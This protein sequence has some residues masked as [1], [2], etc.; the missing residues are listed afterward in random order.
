MPI[1]FHCEACKKKIK[2]PDEAGGKWGACPYCKHRCYIPMPKSDDEPELK[3]A[4][5]D[6][7]EEQ[8]YK[9][10]MRETY[11]LTQNILHETQT[12]AEGATLSN[13]SDPVP[14]KE[15]IRRIIIYLR[16]MAEGKLEEADD[17]AGQLQSQSEQVKDLL[18]R[19]ARTEQ[20]EPELADI[21]PKILHGFMKGLYAK[22]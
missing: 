5:I 15:L 19:M 9:Q 8:Q 11:N 10:M 21:A 20:P 22:L 1:S 2:A 3:L 12:P 7:E 4:P 16:Q 17:M 18:K 14:E 13:S 6:E